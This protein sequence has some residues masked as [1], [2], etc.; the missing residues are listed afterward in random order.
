M[1]TVS[2]RESLYKSMKK[3]PLRIEIHISTPIVFPGRSIHLDSIL[4]EVVAKE[5]FG[6]DLDRWQDQ[7]KQ[8][9]LPLP[10][11]KTDGIHPIWKA[12]IGFASSLS[13][14]SE[15]FWVKRTNTQ[16]AGYVS[17]DI[18]WPAGVV[19]N[20]VTKS[21]SNR[22]HLEKPTGPANKTSAG[23]FKSYYEKRNLLLTKSLI[24]HAIGN[25]EEIVRLLSKL[26]G[27][28]KKTAIGYGKIEKIEVKQVKEDY[29]LFTPDHKVARNL[30]VADYPTVKAQMIGSRT[31]SP[32]WSKRDLVI[33]F[34]PSSPIPVWKWDEQEQNQSFEEQFMDEGKE[35]NEDDWFDD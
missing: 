7:D 18:V 35:E 34:A 24:F 23:G 20:S 26:D 19:S 22:V 30:P 14:E 27:I 33:C 29:S 4:T 6:N 3:E 5:L 15:D 17:T 28:G 10:L 8:I 1:F 13:R 25:R 9:E 16:F 21:L 31:S 12:S 32:Y 11:E 2:S